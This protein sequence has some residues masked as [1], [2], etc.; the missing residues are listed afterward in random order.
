MEVI[1]NM[2]DGKP[3]NEKTQSV[4]PLIRNKMNHFTNLPKKLDLIE[5]NNKKT[6]THND[7]TTNGYQFENSAEQ[8][9]CICK[10][11][12]SDEED[13]MMI[14]CDICKDWLHF[15]CVNL[16]HRATFDIETY[17]CPRCVSETVQTIC[18]FNFNLKKSV[19][20]KM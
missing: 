13:D 19:S 8:T 7:T 16:T 1:C 4:K 20:S 18:N 6:N 3:F 2:S 10:R 14:E 9:F 5:S 11:N 17:V 12:V 15:K